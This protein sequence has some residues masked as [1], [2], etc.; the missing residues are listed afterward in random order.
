MSRRLSVTFDIDPDGYAYQ[1]E[2]ADVPTGIVVEV[3]VG[4]L[5]DLKASIESAPALNP[6]DVLAWRALERV[7]FSG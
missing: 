7:S 6:A 3:L 5:E 2:P 4:F 1:I